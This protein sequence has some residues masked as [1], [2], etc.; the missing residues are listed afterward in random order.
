M[1]NA[2]GVWGLDDVL[3]VLDMVDG[4]L[5]ENFTLVQ[6]VWAQENIDYVVELG[7]V[8]IVEGTI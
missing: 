5:Q 2:L 8:A 1:E 7:F 4:E 3:H 6:D